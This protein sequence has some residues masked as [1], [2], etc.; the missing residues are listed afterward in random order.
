MPP[1]NS[2]GVNMLGMI[3]PN[4]F[5]RC[6]YI[7]YNNEIVL[8]C[9][10]LFIHLYSFYFDIS[11]IHALV[12]KKLCDVSE[13]VPYVMLGT[14][15]INTP[16]KYCFQT[17]HVYSLLT[18]PFCIL[19]TCRCIYWWPTIKLSR[20]F[21][22]IYNFYCLSKDDTGHFIWSITC[23]LPWVVASHDLSICSLL[24]YL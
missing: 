2:F 15:P 11:Y 17:H 24:Q 7:I 5:E 6:Y 18:V 9:Y 22:V 13:Q 3:L 23:K 14:S 19:S 10:I 1:V 12:F 20:R 4:H 21:Y 8:F 16:S